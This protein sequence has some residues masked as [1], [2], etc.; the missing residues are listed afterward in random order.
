L[1]HD[2][3]AEGRSRLGGQARAGQAGGEQKTTRQS[4]DLPS[5]SMKWAFT[6]GRIEHLSSHLESKRDLMILHQKL[7]RV[8]EVQNVGS[9][10]SIMC[11]QGRPAFSKGFSQSFE[12]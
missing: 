8:S 2:G 7:L 12:F 5:Q 9:N 11:D 6:K 3:K 10:M 4:F 1:R